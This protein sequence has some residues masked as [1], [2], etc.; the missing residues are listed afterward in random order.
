MDKSTIA[1]YDAHADEYAVKTR[2]VYMFDTRSLFLRYLDPDGRILDAGCGGG[3]DMKIFMENGYIVDAF[4]ASEEMCRVASEYTEEDIPCCTFEEW[5]SRYSYSGIWCCASLLHL[6]EEEF[7]AFI[8]KAA[9]YLRSGGVIY[10]SMKDGI[11]DGYDELGRWYL[12]FDDARLEKLLTR[13]PNLKV[14]EYWKT[15]DNL[16]RGITWI[17]VILQLKR[18]A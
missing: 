15:E 18:G 8:E 16:N 17:N 1:Y 6:Q 3:R 10:F 12:G 13:C 11:T 2:Y 4:D 5:T 7:Y 9:K 14:V